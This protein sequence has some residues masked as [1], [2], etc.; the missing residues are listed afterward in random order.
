[1]GGPWKGD[2]L[3][4]GTRLRSARLL[5]GFLAKDVADRSGVSR[6]SLSRLESADESVVD[7]LVL[8]RLAMALGVSRSWLLEPPRAF[9]SQGSHFRANSRMTK[10]AQ[11]TVSSWGVLLAELVATVEQAGRVDLL[12]VT[13]PV[14]D[15]LSID[16]ASAAAQTR[17]ALGLSPSGPIPH[18]IRA[19][20]GGGVFVGTCAFEEDLHLRNHDASSRWATLASGRAVPVVVCRQHSSWERTRFSLAHEVGHLVL[21]RRGGGEA[22]EDEATQFAAELLFPSAALREQW[23]QSATISTLLELKRQYGMSLAALIMHGY[24]HGLISD[25]KRVSLFK[26]L[27]NG[28]D[29][30]TGQRWRV[31][32]PGADERQVERPVLVGNAIEVGYGLPPNLDALMADLPDDRGGEWYGQFLVNFDC[33]WPQE[34][35]QTPQD[36]EQTTTQVEPV[37]A[38]MPESTNVVAFP[39]L[40]RHDV[41]PR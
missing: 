25:D 17:E 18:L 24:R 41:C 10:T 12:P 3:V 38:Q 9:V 28:R 5:R 35:E 15:S 32:E 1:M 20:E 29:R 6:A 39:Q 30:R 31:R 19:V 16:P 4:Q 37:A 34:V 14:L 21:H 8:T 11:E 33:T 40:V 27:S 23:P 2:V 26:Q 13:L 7:P 36:V 22:M